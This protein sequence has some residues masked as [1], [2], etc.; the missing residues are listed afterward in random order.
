[1]NSCKSCQQ[2]KHFSNFNIIVLFKPKEEEKFKSFQVFYVQMRTTSRLNCNF[3]LAPVQAMLISPI[4]RSRPSAKYFKSWDSRCYFL[5]IRWNALY[6]TSFNCSNL[7]IWILPYKRHKN[8]SFPQ[9][10]KT[11]NSIRSTM[12]QSYTEYN[13]F[14]L[15]HIVKIL[16][17]WNL[18]NKLYNLWR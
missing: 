10:Q 17:K 5:L 2:E 8:S 12:Q 9:K 16:C 18:S 7:K 3:H 13:I 6:S 14:K 1:M 15:H 11:L 4:F